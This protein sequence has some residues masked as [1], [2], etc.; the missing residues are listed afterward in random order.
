MEDLGIRG[1][2]YTKKQSIRR[3]KNPKCKT[4]ILDG[5]HRAQLSLNR[6]QHS[7]SFTSLGQL[8]LSLQHLLSFIYVQPLSV[9]VCLL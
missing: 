2:Y 7:F 4:E 8:G 5:I 1:H 9:S 6:S 3:Q